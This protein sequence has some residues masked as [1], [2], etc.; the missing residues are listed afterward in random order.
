MSAFIIVKM[1]WPN[2]K[3]D[4]MGKLFLKVAPML[5]KVLKRVSEAPWF[6]ADENGIIAYNVFETEEGKLYEAL[7]GV[8]NYLNNYRHVEGFRA[9]AEP[10]LTAK[11]TMPMLGLQ[12]PPLK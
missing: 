9:K 5:P 7:K 11:D 4:E 6:T 2:D 1:M 8:F 10:V 3:S 12:A